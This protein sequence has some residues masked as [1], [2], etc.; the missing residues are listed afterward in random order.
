VIRKVKNLNKSVDAGSGIK[1]AAGG[2]LSSLVGG[3]KS[4]A[5]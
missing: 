4:I 1:P 5:S 3:L 2:F